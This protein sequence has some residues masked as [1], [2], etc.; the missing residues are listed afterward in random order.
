MLGIVVL[1]GA[2]VA[3]VV[4]R[5]RFGNTT[6]LLWKLS[7]F[8]V[9]LWSIRMWRFRSSIFGEESG[10]TGGFIVD[11]VVVVDIFIPDFRA[12]G[13]MILVLS[14][15]S[16]RLAALSLSGLASVAL[17]RPELDVNGVVAFLATPV[18][19]HFC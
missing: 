12:S 17:S 4:G 15:K 10:N 3:S 18:N 19:V 5:C 9:R 8:F 16:C 6:N 1:V 11:V 14:T 7:S 2:I 13:M